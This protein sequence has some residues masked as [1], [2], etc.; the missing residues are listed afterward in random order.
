MNGSQEVQFRQLLIVVQEVVT[1]GNKQ[2]KMTLKTGFKDEQGSVQ[3]KQHSRQKEQ[4]CTEALYP[5]NTHLV[6][7]YKLLVKCTPH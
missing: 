2:Q 6:R 1:E 7:A 3:C 4:Q 5:F